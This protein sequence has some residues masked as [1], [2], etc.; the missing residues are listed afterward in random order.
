[1]KHY[2]EL[3]IQHWFIGLMIV[4]FAIFISAKKLSIFLVVMQ[5]K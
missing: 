1:M 4:T 3:I 5:L 2:F